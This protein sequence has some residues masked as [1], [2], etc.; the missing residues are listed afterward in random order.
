ME[1]SWKDQKTAQIW[2]S[3][4]GHLAAVMPF[5]AFALIIY[6]SHYTD[7][8]STEPIPR[9]WY[10]LG[11]S[12][13][14]LPYIGFVPVWICGVCGVM[15][16]L[17]GIVFRSAILFLEGCWACLAVPVLCFLYMVRTF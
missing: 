4:I 1:T 6:I 10:W 7:P 5:V 8:F 15:A 12:H 14:L 2:G 13:I 11:A 9:W 3:S 17:A 16:L